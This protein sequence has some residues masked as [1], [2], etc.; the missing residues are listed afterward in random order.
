M[1][2]RKNTKF[3]ILER[4]NFSETP[5]RV[6]YRVTEFGAKFV[7]ILDELEKLQNEIESEI[8]V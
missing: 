7:R 3:G 2:L 8:E 5:P 1:C 6:E 4:V